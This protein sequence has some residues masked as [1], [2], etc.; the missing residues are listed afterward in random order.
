MEKSLLSISVI[1]ALW[2]AFDDKSLD[3]KVLDDS[4]NV[5]VV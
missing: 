4:A 1:S 2:S 3:I 5:K